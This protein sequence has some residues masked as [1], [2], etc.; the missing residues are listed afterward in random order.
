MN[1]L[2]VNENNRYCS[3]KLKWLTVPSMCSL[4]SCINIFYIIP[5]VYY[6]TIEMY[7]CSMLGWEGWGGIFLYNSIKT[8]KGKKC[9]LVHCSMLHLKLNMRS[10]SDQS[11]DSLL[12]CVLQVWLCL[13]ALGLSCLDPSTG[14][15]ND[16]TILIEQQPEFD[17]W[18]KRVFSSGRQRFSPGWP[19]TDFF[20]HTA[21]S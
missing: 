7:C 16:T 11:S 14:R 10:S 2:S 5:L 9:R 17:S 4:M 20:Q 13:I 15:G 18:I 19:F 1:R 21:H 6:F 3:F 12:I 8:I